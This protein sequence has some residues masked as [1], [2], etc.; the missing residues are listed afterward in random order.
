MSGDCS[1]G[2]LFYYSEPKM[3]SIDVTFVHQLKGTPIQS[4]FKL[5]CRKMLKFDTIATKQID[6]FLMSVNTP[7]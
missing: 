1:R 2:P 5:N 4:L 7:L 3:Q 6:D